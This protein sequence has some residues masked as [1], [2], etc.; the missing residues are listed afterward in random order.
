MPN[1]KVFSGSSHRDL[2]NKVCD[3]LG[4]EAGKVVTKKFANLETCVEVGE[5]VRGE[6]VYIVQVFH[7][8]NKSV[9][10][11]EVVVAVTN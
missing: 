7:T 4:I 8:L 3:R 2:T 10:D 11:V 5:S 6:D 9:D 1:I